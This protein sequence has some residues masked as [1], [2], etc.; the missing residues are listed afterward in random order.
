MVDRCHSR[1]CHDSVSIIS[2]VIVDAAKPNTDIPR[3]L[4]STSD[5]LIDE[6][7]ATAPGS[8]REMLDGDRGGRIGSERMARCRP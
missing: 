3:I 6:I 2:P 1:A 4:E 7:T 8:I 5:S